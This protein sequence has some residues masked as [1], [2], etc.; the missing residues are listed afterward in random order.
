LKIFGHP[1]SEDRR[2]P[3]IHVAADDAFDDWILN[4]DEGQELDH[5]STRETAELGR[6]GHRPERVPAGL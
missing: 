6:R 5:Y 1:A 4:D 2:T 3:A